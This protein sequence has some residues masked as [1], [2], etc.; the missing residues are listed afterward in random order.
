MFRRADSAG[1][2]TQPVSLTGGE[3]LDVRD[4]PGTWPQPLCRHRHRT[5]LVCSEEQSRA[6][7]ANGIRIRTRLSGARPHFP[8]GGSP[9]PLPYSG[10]VSR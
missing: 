5:D 9:S 7:V 1:R 8:L 10:V 2:G 3:E 6:L 4:R